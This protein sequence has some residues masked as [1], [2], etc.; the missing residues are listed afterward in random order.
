MDT[1]LSLHNTTAGLIRLQRTINLAV[2]AIASVGLT[3]IGIEAA[4]ANTLFSQ[5][6]IDASRLVAVASPYGGNAHQL[7][8]LEQL[9]N[10]RQCW[11]ESGTSP[12]TI[13]PLLLE[14]DFTDICSRSV[15]SNGYSVRVGGEDLNW[16][17]SL[18][19]V[20]RNNDIVL[21]AAPNVDRAAPELVVA[22]TR[23]YTPGF[24]KFYL[25]PGWRLTKRA[26]QGTTTGH[27]YLTHNQTLASL[28]AAAIASR[29]AL[30]PVA[31][32]N[33]I[34]VYTPAPQPVTRPI[35]R[36]VP[37]PTTPTVAQSQRR[38]SLWERLFGARQSSRS[39]S[40]SRPTVRPTDTPW[41]NVVPPTTPNSTNPTSTTTGD[42]IVPTVNLG[43]P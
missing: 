3:T 16:R 42:V 8:I 29:P 30:P 23:G 32:V 20:R 24:A 25:E 12:T 38:T 1:Q 5:Q 31:T 9:S 13:N 19:A 34:P 4:T 14:F 2:L 35:A 28:N 6:E 22:R 40:N 37:Q 36:P 18:R 10:A 11:S 17:Y 15:D 41:S 21:L 27:I 43:Q 26:Y 7:L 39:R 33:P